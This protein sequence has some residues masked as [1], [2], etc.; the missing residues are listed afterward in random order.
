MKKIIEF[1]TTICHLFMF[2]IKTFWVMMR[3]DMQKEATTY[4]EEREQ[5][6]RAKKKKQQEYRMER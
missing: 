2:A 4:K 3:N 6:K 1:F 5:Q